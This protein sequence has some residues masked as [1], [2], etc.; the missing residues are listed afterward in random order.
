VETRPQRETYSNVRMRILVTGGTG[1]IG[2]ALVQALRQRGDEPVIVSRRPS[3]TAVG[4]DAIEHEV[5]RA[6]AIVHLAG[7]PIADSRWTEA[8]KQ[9]IRESRIQPTERI[10]RAVE[11]ASPRPRVLVSASAVGI[12]GMREDDRVLDEKS[13]AGDGFLAQLAVAWESKADR[14][15]DAG[16]RVVH[17]RI[18]IVLGRG[19]GALGRMVAPYRFFVG[20]PI[21]SGRQWVSWIHWQDAVRALLFALDSDALSGPVNVVAPE[22]VRMERLAHAIGAALNRPAA[23][24]VPAFALRLAL[25]EGLA[26]VLLT[27]QRAVPRRLLDRG[28]AFGFSRIEQACSDLVTPW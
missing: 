13:P 23:M 7:E 10:A 18:G 15:R 16:V 12:Y 3:A 25:G 21:G 4:W 9:R 8:R 6:D 2:G 11:Q 17:P 28:F 22:P 19:G 14:A 26:Q 5:A 20:G 1:F 24:R 27:G